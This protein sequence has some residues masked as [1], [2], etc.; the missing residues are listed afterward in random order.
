MKKVIYK[1]WMPETRC[2][3]VNFLSIGIFHTWGL[4]LHETSDQMASFSVA[5]VETPDGNI[6]E[7]L[8]SNLKFIS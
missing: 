8:P 1:K 4:S 7:V 5:L 2:F 3:E 6:E